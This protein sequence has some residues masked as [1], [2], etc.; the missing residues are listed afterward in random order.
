MAQGSQ[1]TFGGWEPRTCCICGGPIVKARVQG[2]LRFHFD[3]RSGGVASWHVACET[4]HGWPAEAR[5]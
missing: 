4:E 3:D 5:A 1:T 2:G